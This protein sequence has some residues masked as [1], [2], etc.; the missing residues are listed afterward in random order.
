MSLTIDELIEQIGIAGRNSRDL[1]VEVYRQFSGLRGRKLL[2]GLLNRRK[3][4]GDEL[5]ERCAATV[6]SYGTPTY[7]AFMSIVDA[8]TAQ[9]CFT[10]RGRAG[11]KITVPKAATNGEPNIRGADYFADRLKQSNEQE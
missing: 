6:F 2:R 1:A 3:T 4:L 9:Q 7:D 11:T 5:F 10:K 8:S